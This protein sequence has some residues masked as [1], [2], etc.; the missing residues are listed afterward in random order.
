MARKSRKNTGAVIE[1]PV[2]ISNYFSTAIYVRLSIENSG[3]DDDGDSIANQI[4]FCKAYLAEHTDL[5]L[6]GIY[7]DNG[8]KG[9]NF[10]RPEFKRMMDDIRS[11]KVKCVLVKDLSCFGRDYIEAGE[12]LEKIFPF[13]GIRFISITDGY[14]SLTC[15]DAESALMIPLKNMIN[16]VYAKDISRKI[17]TSFKARQEKGEFLPAF[18]PYGYV[19]SKEVAYRYEIDQATAPY[20][21]MIFEWK[22]E[23]VSHNEI[24]K[25]LNDMGAVTPARRKVDLGIWRAEKY[26]HTVWHGRTIIDIMKNPTYTGC[27]VYGRIPKSLYEGIKMH[28]APEEEWRYVPDA[29]EPIISQELFDKVQKMF[30]D[31]AEKFK[32][33]MDENA[34]LRELVTNHFKGKIYCGDCG[35]R[36][37]FVKPTDKRYP[38]DQDH[39]VYVC[40]GYLDSGYSRCSRHSIR[41]PVVADSVLAAINMQLELALK[42]EQLIRQMRGSVKEKNLIDKYVGQINYLSQELKKINGKRESLFENFAEGILDEAEYQFAKKKYDDEA[43]EIEKKLTVEKAKK[44][45]LDDILSLSNE[46]LVAIHEAE[47]VTEIDAGLVKHLVSSVKIFEDNRVEVELNFRDQRNIFNRIIAEM[48]GEANE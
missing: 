27:I 21:R 8:E 42:Q 48:A 46:W 7:E 12:Y 22:A 20:V 5:K 39:A 1:A 10:D 35:K 41:Y 33:K 14:D 29:H 45:Q 18:A 16:D 25:R 19:K 13:M 32:A 4:S 3:K 28:R 31:R 40:G 44:V 36:M 34:P 11:G 24:C 38:V 9:T 17:I 37:R 15:D 43:A 47:N 26:K 30:A 6:Y 2:Q 23:G